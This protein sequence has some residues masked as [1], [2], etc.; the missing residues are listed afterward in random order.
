MHMLVPGR[1]AL[2]ESWSKVSIYADHATGEYVTEREDAAA[3]AEECAIFVPAMGNESIE[4]ADYLL[5]YK[6]KD[7]EY[8][9]AHGRPI[10]K[11]WS[12]EEINKLW[13]DWMELK[14]KRFKGQTQSGPTAT[15][16]RE[17][18]R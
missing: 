18:G 8:R 11:S 10:K 4:A 3:P 12:Y 14:I 16:Q 13:Q 6:K 17:K 2:G 5:E 9:K 7:Q 15:F 1:R